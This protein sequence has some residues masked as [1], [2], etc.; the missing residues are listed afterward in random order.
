MADRP[1]AREAHGDGYG[2][3]GQ[4]AG[5]A[6]SVPWLV[7]VVRAW[8][9][10]DR[11]VVRMTRSVLGRTTLVCVETSGAAAGRRLAEWLDTAPASQHSPPAQNATEDEP[12]TPRRRSDIGAPPTVS[13]GRMAPVAGPPEAT[14]HRHK[15]S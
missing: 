3:V 1:G 15:E 2:A 14:R 9:Q 6:P 5:G 10:E 12:E 4:D 13:P 7:V 8:T 11:R